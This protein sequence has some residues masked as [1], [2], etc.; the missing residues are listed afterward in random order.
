MKAKEGD[1]FKSALDG[2]EYI[3]K[4]VVDSMVVLESQDGKKKIMTGVDSLKIESF[5]Q[6]KED[7]EG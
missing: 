4:K 2:A 5:Y 7:P 3:V 1:I 6:K